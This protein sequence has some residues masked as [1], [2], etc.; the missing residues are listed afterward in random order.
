[1]SDVY[2]HEPEERLELALA[3][4]KRPRR[5]TE[6]EQALRAKH[7][8]SVPS[9]MIHTAAHHVYVDGAPAV[10]DFLADAEL[11]IRDKDHRLSPAVSFHILY[12]V[13][14]WLL[15]EGLLPEGRQDLLELAS[16]LQE[17]VKDK[18]WEAVALTVE[19]LRDVLDGGRNPPAID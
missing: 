7:P 17:L 11:A 15:F 13:Y 8:S 18:D 4:M 10:I 5:D 1:M 12:H 9:A 2:N 16:Q 19:E 3:L 14:N 6:G